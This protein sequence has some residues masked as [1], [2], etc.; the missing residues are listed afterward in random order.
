M[1]AITLRGLDDETLDRL[2][3]IAREK[4]SSM[5]RLILGWVEESLDRPRKGPD[6]RYH[7]LDELF[8]EMTPEDAATIAASSAEQRKVDPELWES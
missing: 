2:R 7:D 3:Q 6:G 4:G 1:G 5:N 8:G